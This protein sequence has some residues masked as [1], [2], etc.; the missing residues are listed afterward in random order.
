MNGVI[1]QPS[2]LPWRGYFDLIRR[3]DVFVFYDDVQYD[4]HGWRN[5]NRIKTAN[6][7]QWLTVPVHSKGNTTE[8]VLLADTKINYAQDWPRK[9]AMTIR[10]SYSRAPFFAEYADTFD[11]F[12]ATRHEKLVDLTIQTT[13][14]LARLLGIATTRFVRSSELKIEGD[15]TERLVRILQAV[16]ATHY[17]SG[18]SAKSYIDDAMF[19][20]AGI[21]LEYIVYDYPSYPQLHTPYDPQVSAIDLLVMAG[22]DAPRY[23]LPATT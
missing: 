17:I 13:L 12:F 16:G 18:P 9:H 2:Y 8:R 6:G 5:R 7:P 15:R 19:A 23:L 3:A 20:D 4:K 11:G 22:R 21:G 10:Q 14:T 1:L